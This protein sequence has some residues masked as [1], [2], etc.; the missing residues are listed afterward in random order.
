[1]TET[2]SAKQNLAP[3]FGSNAPIVEAFYEAYLEDPSSV[4]ESWKRYF[5]DALGAKISGE[6]PHGPIVERR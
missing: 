1:M 4:D 5:D 3:F 2:I 6:V